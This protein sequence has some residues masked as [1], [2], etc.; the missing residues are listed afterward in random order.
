MLESKAKLVRKR[1]GIVTL[2]IPIA[3]IDLEKVEEIKEKIVA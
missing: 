1:Y 2:E 3:K